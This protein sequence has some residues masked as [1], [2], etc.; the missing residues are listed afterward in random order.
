MP[1]HFSRFS[2]FSSPSGNPACVFVCMYVWEMTTHVAGAHQSWLWYEKYAS[3]NI[4]QPL[5]CLRP[6]H[7]HA[8]NRTAT[9]LS[10]HVPRTVST[11]MH[12][13]TSI[14]VL[15]ALFCTPRLTHCY[16]HGKILCY[17]HG[18]ILLC[19]S[20]PANWPSRCK[21][22]QKATGLHVQGA[23]LSSWPPMCRLPL[24][25]SLSFHVLVSHVQVSFHVQGAYQSRL[26]YGL[27][28]SSTSQPLR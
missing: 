22:P 1:S 13:H 4:S 14:I 26:W 16:L 12:T 15:H 28:G 8:T 2:S 20:N 11:H 7:V 19:T 3:T 18:K 21:K 25:R 5:W 23:Y 24:M 17:L 10:S 9:H 27:F 6:R